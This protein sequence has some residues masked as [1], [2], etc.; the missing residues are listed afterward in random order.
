VRASLDGIHWKE[1]R[2]VVLKVRPT[3]YEHPL[4]RVA[5]L[6]LATGLLAAFIHWRTTRLRRAAEALEA[7]VEERTRSLDQRNQELEEANARVKEALASKVALTRMVVHDLR[8]P[9]TTLS[10]LVDH[11]ALDSEDAG[12]QPPAQLETMGRELERLEGLLR[13]MLDQSK[14][15][16][17]DQTLHL[18]P[19]EPESILA[20]MEEGL[21][22]KAERAGLGFR[23]E[24]KAMGGQV[25]ADALAVQQVVLNLFSNA[26]KVTP[27]GGQVG[28]RSVWAEDAWVLE[29]WDTGRGMDPAS[30]DR[31]FR[32]FTQVEIGDM[33]QG[34]GLGLSIVKSLADAHSALI[35][36]ETAPGQGTRFRIA[37]PRL[38]APTP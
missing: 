34:W 29:V 36:V 2:P 27:K 18:A 24:Q 8:T 11:L 1:G 16:A 25:L 32:P 30:V 20:G 38:S 3:W 5:F 9:V 19:A 35:D 31:L 4:G 12:Q 23:W 37:F 26:L 22:L 15:E 33:E 7:K 10:L 14:I 28:V 6:L 13:R 17:V 21:G